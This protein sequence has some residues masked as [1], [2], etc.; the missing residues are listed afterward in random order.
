LFLRR[1][2]LYI[3][4]SLHG[5]G[6]RFQYPV[7]SSIAST[8]F[9][10]G[11]EYDERGA[12]LEKYFHPPLL[13]QEP[14]KGAE[15]ESQCSWINQRLNRIHLSAVIT[16]YYLIMGELKGILMSISVKHAWISVGT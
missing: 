3:K 8:C 4:R 6:K 1:E 15:E 7:F 11:A 2:A 14:N 9:R 12:G 16:G 5:S 10:R 13:F